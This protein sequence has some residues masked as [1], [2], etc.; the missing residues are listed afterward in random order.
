[1]EPF[2]RQGA[3]LAAG[4][5]MLG[6]LALFLLLHFLLSIIPLEWFEHFYAAASLAILNIS[7][8]A[9][10]IEMGEPVLMHIDGIALPIGISYLCTGILEL[11]LV[12]A[13]VLASFG[14]GLKER[15]VGAVAATFVL[16]VFNVMRIA[17]SILAIFYFGLDAGNFS[18]DVLFRAFLFATIAGYYF[19]WFGW[20]SGFEKG[21]FRG[22]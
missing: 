2:F 16:A 9:G 6:M 8:V 13:A 14:T 1:M 18:H 12:W 21:G 11:A 4:K 20:A 15:V 10:T 17:A 3:A 22:T 5:F 19:L 7:G